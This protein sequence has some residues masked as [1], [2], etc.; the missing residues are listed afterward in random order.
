MAILGPRV[1]GDLDVSSLA[2]AHRFDGSLITSS[3]T[4]II[5][6]SKD[7]Y[8]YEATGASTTLVLPSGLSTDLKPGSTFLILN[9]KT[10]GDLSVQANG[11]S[12]E[13]DSVKQGQSAMA[14]LRAKGSAAGSWEIIQLD[15]DESGISK[16][17]GSFNMT[18]DWNTGM[19][20]DF[21]TYTFTIGTDM[22]SANPITTLFNSSNQSVLAQVISTTSGNT[23][24]IVVTVPVGN[25]FAGSRVTI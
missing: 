3:D 2:V 22:I 8:V 9:N 4:T 1:Q 20:A 19:G 15:R 18:T 12:V 5:V 13:L 14:V 23:H 10:A 6:N 7:A 16:I 25:T 24:T 17:S 11:T 21:S